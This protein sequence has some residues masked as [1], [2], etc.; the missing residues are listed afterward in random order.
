MVFNARET[1]ASGDA[2]GVAAAG[3][4]AVTPAGA[5][6][7]AAACARGAHPAI[8]I[9]PMRQRSFV[10]SPSNHPAAPES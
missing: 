5:T 7:L 6:V 1:A 3:A 10:T 9:A 4:L 8:A 2:V